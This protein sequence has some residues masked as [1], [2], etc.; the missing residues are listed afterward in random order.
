MSGANKYFEVKF[1]IS[2]IHITKNFHIKI[3]KIIEN[4]NFNYNKYYYFPIVSII[5]CT[6]ND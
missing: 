1:S 5:I 4:G 6:K 3:A 2:I